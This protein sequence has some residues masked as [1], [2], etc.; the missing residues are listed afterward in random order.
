MFLDEI[1][2]NTDMTLCYGWAQSS[3]R[4]VDH[5]PLNTPQ[6]TTVLPSIRF[7]GE[8]AFTTY[9]S[10]TTEERFVAYL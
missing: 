2:V 1:V 3:E 8:K 6:T 10:G 7:N 5:A 9:Q 4:C